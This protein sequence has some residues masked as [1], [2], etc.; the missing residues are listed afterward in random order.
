MDA[1]LPLFTVAI[2]GRTVTGCSFTLFFLGD[3]ASALALLATGRSPP[4]ALAMSVAPA[5]RVVRE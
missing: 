1:S 5:C 2:C 3:S 4:A